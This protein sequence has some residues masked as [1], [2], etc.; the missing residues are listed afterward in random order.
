MCG[1]VGYTGKSDCVPFL[2]EGLR[3]LEYRGYD[4]AGVAVVRDGCPEKLEVRKEQGVLANLVE[5]LRHGRLQ[6]KTGIGH[7]RWATHGKPTQ[8]NAHPHFSTDGTVGV[9]HNGIVENH[10]ELREELL[11]RGAAFLS[12]TDTEIIPHLVCDYIR[13]G[14]DVEQAFLETVK[15][16]EGAFAIVMVSTRSPGLLFAAR[17]GSPLIAGFGKEEVFLASDAGPLLEHTREVLYL[18][19]GEVLVTDGGTS[20]LMDCEGNPREIALVHEDSE[21]V[22]AGMDGFES[23]TLKEIHEQPAI[24]R[25]IIQMRLGEAGDGFSVRFERIRTRPD[26]LKHIDR[27]YI[28][29]CGTAYHAAFIGKY[30]LEEFLDL[31][32]EV[33]LSSEFR[34]AKPKLNEKNLV[35]AV[36]QSGETADTLAGIIEAKRSGSPIL[37]VVNVINSSIDRESDCIVYTHAGPEIGVASTKAFTS[38]V[39]TLLLLSVY[40]AQIRGE[41]QNGRN[42]I[43]MEEIRALPEK[44]ERIVAMEKQI[45]QC[46]LKYHLATSALYLGRHLNYPVA[47]EG[48]LKNKEISYMHAEGYAAG[49]M[50]HGP[51]ALI[52][53]SLP[54]ICIATA[55]RV[56][57]KMISNIKEVEAREGIIITVATEGDEQ[58]R[59]FSR[60]V[61]YVPET[62]EELAPVLN[63]V[64][65]Q[66]LAYYFA[67]YKG[68][69]IDKPRNLA[70]SVTVE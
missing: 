35:I 9:V 56:Y 25:R 69:E 30:Y 59:R 44:V 2:M 47:L 28:T 3:R 1:I 50:K 6:G 12:D 37:S 18:K 54:V 15:R 39:L 65:L 27:I 48:A 46:A 29:G 22:F 7:T 8:E 63:V 45:A 34:Y 66:L 36:S 42:Q 10:N 17:R 61:L 26:F 49:E 62:A 68:N 21:N 58:V 19:E 5:S 43:L 11:G 67:R 14:L 38:Q 70:K 53:R 40:I 64:V 31:P 41:F 20:R 55:S 4:S 57:D 23:F 33:I 60:E 51:I 52:D 24:L 13:R 16:L 32:V